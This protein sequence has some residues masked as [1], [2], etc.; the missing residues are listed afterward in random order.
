VQAI[1]V[2]IDY[3]AEAAVGDREYFL[4]KPYRSGGGIP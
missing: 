1:I 2:A 3:Y 4:N